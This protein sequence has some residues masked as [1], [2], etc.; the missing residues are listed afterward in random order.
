MISGYLYDRYE[1]LPPNGSPLETVFLIVQRERQ[2]AE[3]L[4]VKTQAQALL[5]ILQQ[6]GASKQVAKPATDAF[7]AYVDHVLPVEKA[8]EVVSDAHK[9]LNDFVKYP[10]RINQQMVYEQRVSAAR[11][12]VGRNARRLRP[13]KAR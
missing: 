3:M 8:A 13:R 12:K 4:A 10:A 11:E 5:L 6:L 9:V 7:D 2:R 1:G